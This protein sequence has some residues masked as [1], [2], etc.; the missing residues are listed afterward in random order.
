MYISCPQRVLGS[1]ARWH[2]KG[3]KL[4]IA[5]VENDRDWVRHIKVLGTS[6]ISYIPVP[7]LYLD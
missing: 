7:C 2:W 3:C 1:V 5:E 6:I 4:E